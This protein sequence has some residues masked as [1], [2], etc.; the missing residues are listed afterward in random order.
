MCSRI[1]VLVG[2]TVNDLLTFQVVVIHVQIGGCRSCDWWS[3]RCEEGKKKEHCL[4]CLLVWVS[5]MAE[6]WRNWSLTVSWHLCTTRALPAGIAH[7]LN[8]KEEKNDISFCRLK[9]AQDPN[10]FFKDQVAW[11]R[12]DLGQIE[13]KSTWSEGR[14]Y[15]FSILVLPSRP[16]LDVAGCVP[17]QNGWGPF[18]MEHRLL[19]IFGGRDPNLYPALVIQILL[20]KAN[21]LRLPLDRLYYFPVCDSRWASYFYLNLLLYNFSPSASSSEIDH[22]PGISNSC[23]WKAFFERRDITLCIWFTLNTR[24]I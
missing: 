3:D 21:A 13:T 14:S 5:W 23:S 4:L 22:K 6:M 24:C 9:P 19:M 11:F 20:Q 17:C 8:L 15:S 10:N 18:C 12:R 2:S 16:V 1:Y 7:I